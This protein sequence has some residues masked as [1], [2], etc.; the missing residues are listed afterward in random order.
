[1]RFMMKYLK[2][3]TKMDER[4]SKLENLCKDPDL[5]AEIVGNDVD[6]TLANLAKHGIEMTKEEYTEFATGIVSGDKGHEE[7]ELDEEALSFVAGGAK[8]TKKK[9]NLG[10]FNGLFDAADDNIFGT[11]KGA[12][13][14]GPLY[15]IGYSIGYGLNKL[16]Y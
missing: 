6:E 2:G 14:S 5:M 7:G 10:F 15:A 16:F 13:K 11:A 1:M 3:D 8:K 12:K 9:V 4:I